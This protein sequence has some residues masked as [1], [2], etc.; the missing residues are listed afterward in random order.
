MPQDGELSLP[1]VRSFDSRIPVNAMF[2]NQS[3]RVV[4]PLWI[5]YRGEPKPYRDIHPAA[6]VPMTT[7]AVLSLKDR[8]LQV[9]RHLVRP[10]DYRKLEIARS[11][12]DDLEEEPSVLR[13]LHRINQR[14]AQHLLEKLQ[15][16]EE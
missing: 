8:A 3:S 16:Q 14:V 13:D 4:R 12:H 9:I 10:E 1:L 15:G 5:D 2:C 11:L 7:F 6:S